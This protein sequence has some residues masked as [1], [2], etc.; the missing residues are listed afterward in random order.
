M[1]QCGTRVEQV[2]AYPWCCIGTVL[3]VREGHVGVPEGSQKGPKR[4]KT[5]FLGH[6]QIWWL[7]TDGTVWNKGGSSQGTSPVMHW[8]S[9]AGQGGPS[10]GTRGLPKG[11][12]NGQKQ[13]FSAISGSGRPKKAPLTP[14]LKVDAH[15]A[16]VRR[17]KESWEDQKAG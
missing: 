6:K 12:K 16:H 15:C 5:A 17:T 8:N 2:M 14:V 4:P 3:G 1:E 7:Q 10:R 9:F 11:S 13:P